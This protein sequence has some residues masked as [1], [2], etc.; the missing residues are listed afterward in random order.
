MEDT[1]QHIKYLQLKVWMDKT[2]ARRLKQFL[3]DN[4]ALQKFWA[5]SKSAA[6]KPDSN[7]KDGDPVNR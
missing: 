1:P 4:D 3:E 6:A 5:K 7:P 2:P